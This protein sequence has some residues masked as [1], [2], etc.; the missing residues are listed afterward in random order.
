MLVEEKQLTE[1]DGILF[2]SPAEGIGYQSAAA[3]GRL[4]KKLLGLVK[5]PQEQ[6]RLNA[7][8]MLTIMCD[9]EHLESPEDKIKHPFSTVVISPNAELANNSALTTEQVTSMNTLVGV[10]SRMNPHAHFI[11][12]LPNTTPAT[13]VN[14]LIRDVR[15]QATVLLSPAIFGFR[16][17]ALMDQALELA[18]KNPALL[19]KPLTQNF[20][21]AL[22]FAADIAGFIVSLAQN[23]TQRNT[24]NKTLYNKIIRVPAAVTNAGDFHQAFCEAFAKAASLPQ[25][26][27]AIFGRNPLE[28]SFQRM[29]LSAKVPTRT[30]DEYPPDSEVHALDVF[31]TQ[32]TPLS[33]LMK[34]SAAQ[35]ARHP[36]LELHFPP[37]RAL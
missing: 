11:F 13:L 33:K 22:I 20:S 31:P 23:K 21:C 25:K 6:T 12:V 37:G 17:G 5:T 29:S 27:G 1:S 7:L 34:Q 30:Q 35:L 4:G 24:H 32:L 26:L 18:K 16:D 3:F 8:K 36:E 28:A 9:W 10:L 19:H 14:D 2:A 15:E